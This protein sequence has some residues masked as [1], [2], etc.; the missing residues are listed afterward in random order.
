[1]YLSNL[2]RFFNQHENQIVCETMTWENSIFNSF[3]QRTSLF[4]R[5]KLMKNQKISPFNIASNQ[6]SVNNW[7][8]CDVIHEYLFL[9]L[10]ILKG[11]NAANKQILNKNTRVVNRRIKRTLQQ[12]V[13]NLGQWSSMSKFAYDICTVI[14]KTDLWSK[15]KNLLNNLKTFLRTFWF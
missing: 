15:H 5:S 9:F 1:M 7:N 6:Y 14:Q 13:K 4:L 8:Y 3:W 11:T 10:Y 2:P 12:S